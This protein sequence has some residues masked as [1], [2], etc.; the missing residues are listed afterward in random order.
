M[1]KQREKA[2]GILACDPWYGWHHR[3]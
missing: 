2:W 3:F 1:K